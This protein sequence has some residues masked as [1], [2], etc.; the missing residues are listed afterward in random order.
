MIYRTPSEKIKEYYDTMGINQSALKVILKQGVE[1]F[2]HDKEEIL[3]TDEHYY[4]EKEHFII[5]KGVDCLITEGED[6]FK[7]Q[8]H[9]NEL[10][11][12]P[13]E[14]PMAIVK[15]VY[16]IVEDR[17][18][19]LSTYKEKL[20]EAMNTVG[21]YNNTAKPT[22]QEDGARLERM[23]KDGLCAAYWEDLLKAQG[24]QILA[25]EQ[26]DCINNIH[27]SL[28]THP[29]TS[30]LFHP[31]E[32]QNSHMDII[33]QLPIYW[34]EEVN[35]GSM[36]GED[37]EIQED[38][39]C[40]IDVLI[41]NHE[42]KTVA[43]I[44]IKTTRDFVTRF[45]KHVEWKRY[46]IQAAYYTWALQGNLVKI[47]EIVGR[48]IADYK[49]ENFAFVVESS[50]YPGTPLIFPLTDTLIDIGTDGDIDGEKEGWVQALG[51][52]ARF[53]KYNFSVKELVEKDGGIVWIND[54]FKTDL[55]I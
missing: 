1:A 31:L 16:D 26:Y 6:A 28:I 4:E 15:M 29:H 38:C 55:D 13:S 18:K 20:Y 9:Y 40:L 25:K 8:F 42:K 2:V 32:Y 21:F 27:M 54:E 39:K 48:E 43:P 10:L 37:D 36:D 24:K 30:Y 50:N 12:K 51:Y 11:K 46:D 22:W 34:T 33:Y 5:G 45:N 44:D 35:L 23:L 47:N 41:I 53:K 3:K 52:Y 7:A 19:P 17:S 14:K 49:I